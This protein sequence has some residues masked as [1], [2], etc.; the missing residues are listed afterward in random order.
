M[1]L[2]EIKGFAPKLYRVRLSLH[3]R[4]AKRAAKQGISLQDAVNAA[5]A[6]YLAA[7]KAPAKAKAIT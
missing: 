3:D 7:P 5:F 2:S 4:M 1:A 6:A